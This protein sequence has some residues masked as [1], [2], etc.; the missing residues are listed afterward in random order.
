MYTTSLPPLSVIVVVFFLA[1]CTLLTDDTGSSVEI[2]GEPISISR[3]TEPSSYDRP[4]WVEDAVLYEISVRDFTQDGTFRAVI[5]HLPRLKQM[6]VTALWLMPIHPIGK[7]RR[8]GEWGSPYSVRDYYAVNSNYGSKEDFRALV[9]AV[10]EHDMRILLDLVANHTAWDHPWIEEHP[11]WYEQDEAGDITHPEGTDWTDVAALNYE[12]PEVRTAMKQVMQYWVEEFNID[13]YRGDAAGRVPAD[14]WESAIEELRSSASV[15]M[16]AEAESPALHERGFDVSYSWNV[17]RTLNAIWNGAPTSRLAT[18]L[19]DERE[20]FP[21]HALRLRF[22]TN[23]D[24]VAAD[25]PPIALFNGPRGAQAAALLSAVVPGMPLLYNGQE[26]GAAIPPFRGMSIQ[27]DEHPDMEAFY[28]RLLR[29]IH[30]T[31][32]VRRGN[33]TVH[34]PAGT[35][36]I[37]LERTAEQDRLLILINVRDRTVQA[38]LPARWQG[39]SLRDVFQDDVRREGESVTLPGYGYRVYQTVNPG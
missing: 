1:G 8:S 33:L 3:P 34:H 10:H 27:W 24:E 6:G 17:Y 2:E 13:G 19:A 28:T 7:E 12:H 5:P 31:P 16:L 22:T 39:R 36:V 23:H 4:D 14:F 15:M 26:V 18:V 35:D 9:E 11:E 21:D 25:G 29:R 20:T 32:A 38:P 37:V 30:S